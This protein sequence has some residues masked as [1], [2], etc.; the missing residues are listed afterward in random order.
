MIKKTIST[1]FVIF[2]L[3]YSANAQVVTHFKFIT[4]T[5]NSATILIPAA[6]NPKV[7]NVS[8]SAGDEIGVYTSKWLC[9]GGAVWPGN[10]QSAVIT[11]W[12]DNDVTGYYGRQ[13]P[14]P[15]DT[16]EGITAGEK[17]NFAVWLK[18]KNKEYT[19]TNFTYASSSINKTT[20]V[21]DGIYTLASLE[22]PTGVE[23]TNKI[24]NYDLNQ[25][26]PNPFN[27]STTIRFSIESQNPV[28]VQL[29]I[30]DVLGREVSTLLNQSF[31]YGM[32]SVIFDGKGLQSGVYYYKLQAG[33][34]SSMKKMMLMK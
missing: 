18:S 11:I 22:I 1:L 7:M 5:G 24:M 20:Y 15:K 21:P 6:I 10:G 29:K 26:Y 8:L 4:N 17:I 12:G 14:V 33:D 23:G 27:P 32:H 28:P 13:Y 34:Y 16:I 25:N 3:S 31:S 30:Y 9:C 19:N 2:L